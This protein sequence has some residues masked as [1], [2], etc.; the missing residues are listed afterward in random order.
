MSNDFTVVWNNCLQ[1]LRS[2]LTEQDFKTWFD[3]I[4]AVKLDGNVLTLNVPNK[5]FCEWLED[6]FVKVLR[7]AITKEL[8]EHAR[9]EYQYKIENHFEVKK[10]NFPKTDKHAIPGGF[11]ADTIKNPFV[12][13]GIK[14]VKIDPQLKNSYNFDSFIEGDCNRLARSAGI[15]IANNPGNTGFN[16]FVVFGDVGLGKTHLAQAIGNEVITKFP[17]KSVLY[18]SSEKFTNQI[19]EAIKNN[20]VN[21]FVNFYQLVDVLIVDDIQFLANR[22]KTQEIFFHI[23]NQLH[24]DGKQIILTSDC[25]PKDLNGMEERLISRFKWGL[26][27]DI[28]APD[29]ETRIAIAE[30]KMDTK[31]ID[32]PNNV[33]EFI[34]YNIKHN[35]RELEGV[36]IS[37]IAHSSLNQQD[38]DISLAREVI[39]SFISNINKE[40]TI[41]YI[42]KLVADYYDIPVDMLEKQSRKRQFV[43]ARQLSMYLAKKLT[44]ETLKTIGDKFGGRDHSTVLYSCTQVQNMMDT[45]DFFKD[46]VVELEK[47][48]EMSMSA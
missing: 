36:M 10:N 47:R 11:A 14:R 20:A 22:T 31:G 29:L 37:L 19:I 38:I 9:L 32:I 2:Q 5:F 3:P 43:I 28:Q 21:D 4:R 39:Q 24:Q 33:I 17:S 6:N 44:N 35:I 25:A 46:S 8:G 26:S 23:F 42:M 40:I 27:A 41:E 16:P 30:S 34:C 18:V 13:P 12:I 15:A 1:Y 45:D 7:A 48:L